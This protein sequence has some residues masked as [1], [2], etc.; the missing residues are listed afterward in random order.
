[1]RGWGAARNHLLKNAKGAFFVWQDADDVSVPERLWVLLSHLLAD[2][3]CAAVGSGVALINDKGDV[4]QTRGFDQEAFS[5]RGGRFSGVTASYMLRRSA[6]AQAGGFAPALTGRSADI[7]YLYK[8]NRYGAVHN[9]GDILYRYRG[10]ENRITGQV[11]NDVEGLYRVML[12]FL[13]DIG[14][15]SKDSRPLRSLG[16]KAIIAPDVSVSG[17]VAQRGFFLW[18]RPTGYQRHLLAML[19]TM[20]G[21][22]MWLLRIRTPACPVL[23]PPCEA[24]D[25]TCAQYKY[26][27]HAYLIRRTEKEGCAC[28][29]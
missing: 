12:M 6:V 18:P 20:W 28:A 10:D 11:H 24:M 5:L 16:D 15:Y 2:E 4:T 14:L 25:K 21:N 13:D 22:L 7:H 9:V 3:A 19:R 23:L 1:M 26:A 8:V 17:V 27:Y 29:G